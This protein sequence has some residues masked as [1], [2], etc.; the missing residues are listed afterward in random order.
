VLHLFLDPKPWFAEKRYG[1]GAGMP[2]AWQG[3]AVLLSYI[4]AMLGL[5]VLAERT[6]GEALAG[7]IIGMVLLSVALVLVTKARTRGGWQWRWG[8]DG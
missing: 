3:W 2:I 1:Y 4:A 6:H 5:A 7:V 8:E